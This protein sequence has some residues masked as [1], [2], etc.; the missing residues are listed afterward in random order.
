LAVSFSS[1]L[2]ILPELAAQPPESLAAYGGALFGGMQENL[3][4]TAQAGARI[5]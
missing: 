1:D 4:A 5:F 2:S 3:A